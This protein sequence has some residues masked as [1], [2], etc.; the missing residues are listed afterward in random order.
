MVL[1][2]VESQHARTLTV[3]AHRMTS[4]T[5]AYLR[6]H[7]FVRKRSQTYADA[8]SHVVACQFH[9]LLLAQQAAGRDSTRSGVVA[10]KVLTGALMQS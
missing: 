5:H 10:E 6:T 8:C 7:V 4:N 1:H 3:A 2:A 9:L